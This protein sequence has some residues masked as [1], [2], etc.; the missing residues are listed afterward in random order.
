M[1]TILFVL[2]A[3]LCCL[4]PIVYTYVNLFILAKSNI[5]YKYLPPINIFDIL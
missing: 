1:V 2:V 4:I 5:K 3:I